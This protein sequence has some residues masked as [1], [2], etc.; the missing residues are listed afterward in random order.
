M[1]DYD[2]HHWRSHLLDIRGSMLREIAFRVVACVAWSAVVVM[3][4]QLVWPV[5]RPSTVHTLIGVA[6]GLLLVFRTNSSYDRYW[7]GRK[8]WGRIINESRNLAR[9]SRVL[10]GSRDRALHESIVLWTIAFAYAA[11]HGLRGRADLGPV[12][13][14][15]APDEVATLDGPM[16]LPLAVAT[17]ITARLNEARVRGLISDYV[18]MTIDQ[19]VQLLIDYLGG[20]ERI[21]RTPLP[22]A[23]VVHL[24]R[25][26]ILYCFTLP[27]ALVRDFGW[28]TILATL[29]VAYIFFGIEEIGVEIEDPFGTD[30]ND[31][32]LGDLCA[33]IERDLLALI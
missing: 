5:G 25:A 13:D 15:L 26:L 11:M 4:H 19:N 30:D 16:H 2:P 20:C 9:A 21:H 24:R 7:E 18:Q 23:Y 1:I 12:R 8:L 28:S 6:L 3:F 29:L 31:L 22:F 10:V 33:R 32:P 27:F 17:Q 14:R